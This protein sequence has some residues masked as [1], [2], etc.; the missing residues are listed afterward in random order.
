MKKK[1]FV[2]FIGIMSL[3]STTGTNL[4]KENKEKAAPVSKAETIY[5]LNPLF[6][7]NY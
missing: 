7:I 1:M 4:K 5:T 2:L 6:L 3:C